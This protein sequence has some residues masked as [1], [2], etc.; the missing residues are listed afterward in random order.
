MVANSLRKTA[1]IMVNE[2]KAHQ[3]FKARAKQG[4]VK[5]GLV[6]LQKAMSK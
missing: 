1:Q 3:R 5:R 6:L 4:D 2:H